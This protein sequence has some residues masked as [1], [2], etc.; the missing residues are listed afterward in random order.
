[1]N[2]GSTVNLLTE[3][4]PENI[5]MST[6]LKPRLESSL[7]LATPRERFYR[8]YSC[9][10]GPG[11]PRARMRACWRERDKHIKSHQSIAFH[12][13]HITLYLHHLCRQPPRLLTPPDPMD[14]PQQDGG[15]PGRDV[16]WRRERT[17][18]RRQQTHTRR[19]HPTSSASCAPGPQQ[20]WVCGTV[21]DGRWPP[22][23]LRAPVGWLAAERVSGPASQ[24]RPRTPSSCA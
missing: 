12:L 11:R 1:M 17:G 16:G 3:E 21:A 20:S 10:P 8:T 15:G 24:L 23:P 6:E 7:N 14:Y 13:F 18:H 5:D 4:S 2:L 22:V 9:V 19:T